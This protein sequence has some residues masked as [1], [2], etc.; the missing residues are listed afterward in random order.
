V[1]V[2]AV[3]KPV[4]RDAA[5]VRSVAPFAP[6]LSREASTAEVVVSAGD[7]E[8]SLILLLIL[9]RGTGQDFARPRIARRWAESWD[10]IKLPESVARTAGA[11]ADHHRHQKEPNIRSSG[12]DLP[13]HITRKPP[14]SRRQTI[15]G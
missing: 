14:P 8:R 1:D 9:I 6:M 4:S 11:P 3:L 2:S 15:T 5:S 10:A 12:A 7:S 13:G